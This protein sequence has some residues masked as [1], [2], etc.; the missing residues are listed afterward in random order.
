MFDSVRGLR[1][2]EGGLREAVLVEGCGQ[3]V[4]VTDCE[5]KVKADEVL[6][7]SVYELGNT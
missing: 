4:S 5:A 3:G 6:V 2:R 1:Y 7:S